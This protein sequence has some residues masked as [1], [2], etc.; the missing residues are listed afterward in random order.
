MP[1][2]GC[3]NL[4]VP[5]LLFRKIE[6]SVFVSL[7][8]VLQAANM[9]LSVTGGKRKSHRQARLIGRPIL[10]YPAGGLSCMSGLTT[11]EEFGHFCH[12]VK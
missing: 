1:E 6:I 9:Y 4:R 5:I 7:A 11:G 3:R 12:T 8:L 10:S 2:K